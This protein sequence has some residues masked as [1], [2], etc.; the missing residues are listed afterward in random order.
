MDSKAI[1]LNYLYFVIVFVIS[2]FIIIK[3]IIF[4]INFNMDKKD[5][6]NKN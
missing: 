1:I 6:K 5:K 3:T 4:I 2:I